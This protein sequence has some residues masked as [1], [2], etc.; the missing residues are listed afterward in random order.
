MNNN[1][2]DLIKSYQGKNIRIR[3]DKYVCL[4]DM[5]AASGK[6]SGDW[7]RLKKT[8]ELK[9]ALANKTGI[10][11]CELIVVCVESDGNM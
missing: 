3:K 5:A 9:L 8:E 7:T 1:T 2:T 10:P 11:V 6:Q 4:T